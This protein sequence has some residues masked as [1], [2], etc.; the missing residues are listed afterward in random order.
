MGHFFRQIGFAF[1]CFFLVLFAGRLPE[2]L[3]PEFLRRKDGTMRRLEPRKDRA[4]RDAAATPPPDDQLDRAVQLLAL[5][6]RDGRLVDFLFE[7]IAPYPDDQVGAAVREVHA[8]CREVLQRY[9]TVEPVVAG[10][11]GRPTLVEAGFD[12][13]AV[14]LVG[15]VSGQPPFRGV[16]RHRGWRVARVQL[17]ALPDGANRQVVAPAEVEIG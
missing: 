12:P 2:P 15:M 6:Q 9:L 3:P 14:K 8:S 4:S 10:E 13:G 7:D 16:L 1:K 5:L 17:P 11:E